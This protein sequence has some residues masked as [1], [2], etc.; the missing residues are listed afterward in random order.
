M[1]T[2]NTDGTLDPSGTPPY[3]SPNTIAGLTPQGSSTPPT[4]GTMPVPGVGPGVA[5]TNPDS[6]QIQGWA[7]QYLGRQFSDQDLTNLIGQPLNLVQQGIQGSPEAQAYAKTQN[8]TPTPTPSPTGPTSVFSDPATAPF[9]ALLN[10]VISQ[11]S[12]PQQ[13]P[14]YQQGIDQLNSYLKTLN[15]PVYTPDQMNL[16]QT[17]ALDPLSQQHDQARQQ[18]IQRLAAQGIG[19]S[20]GITQQALQQVDQQFQQLRTQTQS[21]FAANAVNLGRQNQATAAQ[22]APQI[23]SLETQQQQLQDPRNLQAANLAALIPALASSRLAAV[24]QSLTNPATIAPLLQL[25]GGFQNTGYT[26]G[27]N[28]GSAI[29]QLLAGLFGLS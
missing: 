1:A 25:L 27:A 12:T 20:S 4:S 10:N 29:S 18:T 23:T 6:G 8:A 2:I 9:E 22:L 17:Q 3:V 5:A 19:P 13:A 24:N 7:N 15:G 21:Q 14:D 28:Y 16:L 11:F 26:Q